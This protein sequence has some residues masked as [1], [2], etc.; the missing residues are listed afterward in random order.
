MAQ[1]VPGKTGDSCLRDGKTLQNI[2]ERPQKRPGI[3]DAWLVLPRMR[4]AGG[5]GVETVLTRSFFAI[6]TTKGL[7]C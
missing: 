6:T 2:G 7:S 3:P 4:L 5:A 1:L